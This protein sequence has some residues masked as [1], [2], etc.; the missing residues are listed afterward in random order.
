MRRSARLLSGGIQQAD[1]ERPEEQ[2]ATGGLGGEEYR[3]AGLVGE[4]QAHLAMERPAHSEA[5][6]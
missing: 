4:S 3:R 5:W 2:R 6:R 1:K